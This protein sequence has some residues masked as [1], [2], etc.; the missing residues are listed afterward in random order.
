[1]RILVTGGNGY[2]GREVVRTLYNQH[3]VYVVDNLRL[4]HLR[5][6]EQ[7]LTEFK[8][9]RGDI[10]DIEFV[11][12]ML[13]EIAPDAIIH[14]AAIHF[15]PECENNP[16]LT[17]SS[18]VSGTVNLLAATPQSCRFVFASSGAVYQPSSVKHEETDFLLPSDIYGLTKLHGEHY[19]QYISKTRGIPSV[20]VRL[21]NV[22]GPGETNPHVL[23]EI[24]A[25]LKA[26]HQVLN[27]GNTSSLRDYISVQDAAQGFVAAAT[28]GSVEAGESVVVNLGTQRAYSV[29]D[30]LDSLRKITGIDFSI[31]RDPSRLRKV[32]RPVLLADRT[33]I[34]HRFGWVPQAELETTL[35]ATWEEPDLLESLTEKY[36]L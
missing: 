36:R 19:V 3:Q 9:W 4:S 14:L 33:K 7:E 20:I 18:N 31:Q 29:D 15:I 12:S 21:F 5:F 35:Q 26:G 11:E 24:I 2:V 6:S 32:D 10:R 30:L 22:I 23:P 8:F 1:M 13:Q 28:R 27:L 25:Q 34:G 16:S 17:I